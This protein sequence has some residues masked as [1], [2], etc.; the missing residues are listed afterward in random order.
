[1]KAMFLQVDLSPVLQAA[2]DVRPD[3]GGSA[4]GFLVTVMLLVIAALGWLAYYLIKRRERDAQK[5]EEHLE[6]SF[7]IAQTQSELFKQVDGS[8][9]E[10]KTEQ[11]VHT[12]LLQ[13]LNNNK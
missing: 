6:K 8:L 1:M 4:Y 9:N 3:S 5:R 12:A 13:S 11:K 7:Q 2:S 10:V